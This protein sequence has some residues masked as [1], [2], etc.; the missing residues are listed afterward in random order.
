MQKYSKAD[1]GCLLAFVNAKDC[2]EYFGEVALIS[3]MEETPLLDVFEEESIIDYLEEKGYAVT[4]D[5]G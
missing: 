5:K 1:V 4:K 2:V 3:A